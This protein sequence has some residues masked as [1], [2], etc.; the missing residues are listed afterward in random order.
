MF[1]DLSPTL[2]AEI[3]EYFCQVIALITFRLIYE[4]YD[5]HCDPT[6]WECVDFKA[7]PVPAEI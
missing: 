1:L 5:T 3:Y 6:A 4:Y 7:D 2:Y